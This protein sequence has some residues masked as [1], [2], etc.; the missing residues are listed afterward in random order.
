MTSGGLSVAG[1][2]GLGGFPNLAETDVAKVCIWSIICWNIPCVDDCICSNVAWVETWAAFKSSNCIILA[3]ISSTWVVNFSTTSAACFAMRKVWLWY[4]WR[5]SNILL[6][7]NAL[8]PRGSR[9]PKYRSGKVGSRCRRSA[10]V[11]EH[12]IPSNS[13]RQA[14]DYSF[15]RDE[16]YVRT[17]RGGRSVSIHGE[18][19]SSR[20]D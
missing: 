3:F 11:L 19:N 2:S 7:Y 17:C 15:V 10:E 6:E 13:R 12:R 16:R 18:S 20:D 1:T 5:N 9:N 8:N 14:W 4:Q